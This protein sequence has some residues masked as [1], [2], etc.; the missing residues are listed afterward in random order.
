MS[1]KTWNIIWVFF[2]VTITVGGL[3][4]AYFGERD[5]LGFVMNN[6]LIKTA[7]WFYVFVGIYCMVY[8]V[9]RERTKASTKKKILYTFIVLGIAFLYLTITRIIL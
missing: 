2:G 4:M 8:S 9:V 3:T 7:I 5:Q 6:K 1:N